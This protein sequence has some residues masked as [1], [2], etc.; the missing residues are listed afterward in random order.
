[1]AKHIKVTLEHH[2]GRRYHAIKHGAGR[3]P[4]AVTYGKFNLRYRDPKQGG[5]RVRVLLD[6]K[7]LPAALE[8]RR[9]KEEELHALPVA[10]RSTR[11]ISRTYSER[12]V[13]PKPAMSLVVST[14]A[15]TWNCSLL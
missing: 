12:W 5:K 7:D 8:A 4:T 11:R 1:M 13:H 2:L 6:V 9:K 10:E 14:T 15:R 3:R